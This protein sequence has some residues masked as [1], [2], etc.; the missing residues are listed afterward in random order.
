VLADDLFAGTVSFAMGAIGAFLPSK[1][2][3]HFS[4]W[5][6]ELGQCAVKTPITTR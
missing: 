3:R 5:P 6:I 1:S 2:S 4:E